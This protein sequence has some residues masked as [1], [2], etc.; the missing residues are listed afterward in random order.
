MASD[1]GVITQMGADDLAVLKT[2]LRLAMQQVDQR[3]ETLRTAAEG[4]ALQPQTIAEVDALET[5]L[6]EALDELRARRAK[7]QKSGE[8]GSASK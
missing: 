7:L 5:K 4:A 8:E 1:A 2:Q 3:E 6:S